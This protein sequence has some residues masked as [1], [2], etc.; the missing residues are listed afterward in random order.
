MRGRGADQRQKLEEAGEGSTTKLPPNAS[1]RSAGQPDDQRAGHDQQQDREPVDRS[2]RRARRGTR[3]PSAAPW[4]RRP[5]RS[6][7]GPAAESR[8]S[9][10]SII[11]VSLHQHRR[12]S[13]PRRAPARYCAIS[14][15]TEAADR[16]RIGFGNMPNR[17]VSDRQ[18][19]ERDDLAVVEIL[20]GGELRLVEHPEDHLAVEPQRI[21]GRQD[22]AERRQRRDPGC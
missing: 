2:W 4:R 11:G 18:R 15:A 13:W 12:R 1:S 21:A 7:A 6:P 20:D 5:A 8:T 19:P 22:D 14:C 3:R 9:K 17:M 16:S 10:V